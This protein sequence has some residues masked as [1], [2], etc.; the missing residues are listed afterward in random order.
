MLKKLLLSVTLLFVLAGTVFLTT[1]NKS[2]QNPETAINNADQIFPASSETGDISEKIVGD[3]DQAS[4]ILYEYADF[5][6][7]HCADW[8]EVV[9]EELTEYPGKIALVFRAYDLGFK[10]GPAAARA[11]TAAQVQGYFKEYK[12]LLFRNQ[13]EWT[14]ITGTKLTDLFA[15]Y[16]QT[17][18]GGSGDLDKFAQDLQSPSVKTRLKFEQKLGKAIN[19]TG[20][21]TFRINGATVPLANLTQTVGQLMNE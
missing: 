3:P 14:G 19:L 18:S 12:D 11:A 20:T 17:A 8:N 6:C 7:P 10:N 16:F 2:S 9:N 21:P 5:A 13:A 15:E 1:R 4:L